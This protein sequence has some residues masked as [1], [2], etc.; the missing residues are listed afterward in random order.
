VLYYSFV[1]VR[2]HL[3]Y[4]NLGQ[5][6]AALF[7]KKR[8][9]SRFADFRSSL[10]KY[11]IFKPA[12][13]VKSKSKQ[14]A[15]SNCLNFGRFWRNEIEV[16]SRSAFFDTLLIDISRFLSLRMLS[17]AFCIHTAYKILY[18]PQLYTQGQV[19]IN[20]RRSINI[21]GEKLL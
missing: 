16:K 18:Y 21:C 5:H 1:R 17:D 14:T 12:G 4:Y 2:V 15:L 8:S 11:H 19:N 20:Q 10:F 6:I 9:R 3:I 13:L 7:Y